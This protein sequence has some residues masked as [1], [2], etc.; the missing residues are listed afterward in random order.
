MSKD[1]FEYLIIKVLEK[2][3]ESELEIE[4]SV[5]RGLALELNKNK[6]AAEGAGSPNLSG[7]SKHEE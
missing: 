4:N 6:S 7:A 2:M 5:N 1:E 3:A